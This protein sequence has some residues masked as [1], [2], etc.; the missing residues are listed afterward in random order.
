MC[1]EPKLTRVGLLPLVF[2]Q[3]FHESYRILG[4]RGCRNKKL[5]STNAEVRN[6]T[7]SNQGLKVLPWSMLRVKTWK[8]SSQTRNSGT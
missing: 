6:P 3:G 8:M 2:D 5:G 7:M 1:R 4:R